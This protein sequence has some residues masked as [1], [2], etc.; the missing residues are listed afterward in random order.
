[1]NVTKNIKKIEHSA[2]E[3]TVTI[4]QA[5]VAGEYRQLLA[6]YAK[7][8]QIPGFRKG[9]VPTNILER[10]FGESLKGEAVADVIEKALGEIFE[11]KGFQQPLPYSQPSLKESPDLN[12]DKD[13]TFTVVYDVMPEV[14]D[15]NMDG[16]EVEVPSVTVGE[17]E[18]KE[19]LKAIQER[20]ALV[21]DKK[22]D[23]AAAKD[24]IATIN[25]CE[26]DKDGKTVAG[27]EREDYVFTIG[28]GQTIF[29]IDDDVIGMKKGETKEVTKKYKKD[30]P[31]EELAGQTK[32]IK[33]TLTALKLRNLP[34]LDDELAQ[35]VNEK[36]KTLDD[37]K[38]DIKKN[39]NSALENRLN[40][41]K[42]TALIEKLV[43]K[44]PIDLPASMCEAELN[45]RWRMMARQFQTTTEQLE[46]IITSSGQTKDQ[47]LSE[48]KPDVEKALKGRIIIEKLLKDKNITVADTEV[49]AEYEKIAENASISVEEVKKH[50]ADAQSKEYLVDDLKEQKLYKELFE[51]IKV[52]KGE[53]KAFAD[54]FKK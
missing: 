31:N 51:K 43:E 9:H 1:M 17:A 15:I 5:D 53:K 28:A 44:N 21:V 4:P 46:K 33:V 8:V 29:E 11:E 38:A 52:K 23:D 41:I 39:L 25:Y 30:H 19:E 12:I 34:E 20:N 45:S 32:K 7:S 16:I 22:D 24:D 3:L 13:L 2:V 49:E 10:K 37:L 36:F 54:L 48:W 6:K 50:Y 35:D 42:T 18:L 14:A 40:E 26:L 27:T 47:M